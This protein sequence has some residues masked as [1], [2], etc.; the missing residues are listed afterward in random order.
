MPIDGIGSQSH[1]SAGVKG[2]KDA[3]ALLCGAASECAITELD[4]AGAA[5]GDYEKVVQGC[6]GVENC[7]GITEWGVTD[8][9]SW[10]ASSDPTLFDASYSLKPA[11]TAL[12][13]LLG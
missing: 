3:L 6:L 9:Q 10:R 7:V 13:K 11:Y 1:L 2:T 4:I 5:P 8:A 12:L